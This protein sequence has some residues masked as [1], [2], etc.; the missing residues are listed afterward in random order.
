MSHKILVV[1]D[2]PD[3]CEILQFILEDKGFIVETAKTC[4]EAVIRLE[5]QGF[6]LVLSDIR[7]PCG[8]GLELLDKL[9][10]RQLQ[11]P[12]VLISG[13]ADIL[14][15]EAMAKGAAALLCK[16]IHREHL[17]EVVESMLSQ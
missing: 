15:D 9:R 7:M 12:V 2:E 5:A 4:M 8:G 13:F 6:D 3:L 11:L 10:D 14:K 1:D 16:P 17:L